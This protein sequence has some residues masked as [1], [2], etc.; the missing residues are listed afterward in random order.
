MRRR[1]HKRHSQLL[2]RR[3]AGQVDAKEGGRDAEELI[4]ER[5]P[6]AAVPYGTMKLARTISPDNTHVQ[7]DSVFSRG[8][9]M[10][11]APIIRGMVR[12][13]KAPI[14]MGVMAQKIMIKP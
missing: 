2:H 9:A 7:K 5:D 13:P 3:N 6:A 8:N 12:F 4:L 11:R 1:K 14:I 10:S